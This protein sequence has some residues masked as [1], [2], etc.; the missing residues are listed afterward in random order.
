MDHQS[1]EEFRMIKAF[2]VI[3]LLIVEFFVG[4]TSVFAADINQPKPKLDL[5][6]LKLKSFLQLKSL[7]VDKSQVVAG[8]SASVVTATVSLSFVAPPSGAAVRFSV[9]PNLQ[10]AGALAS[11]EV[12]S[13]TIPQGHTSASVQIRTFPNPAYASSTLCTLTASY[14]GSS[15][16]VTFTVERLRIASMVVLPATGF[17]GFTATGTLTLSAV[18]APGTTIALTSDHPDVVRFGTIGN[19]QNS[20]NLA[21]DGKSGAIKTFTVVVSSVPKPTTAAIRAT[22]Y[23]QEVVSQI[24][25]K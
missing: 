14:G 9:A 20:G 6:Q 24:S 2:L 21:F 11:P 23:K 16:T 25:V 4:V 15:K 13:V 7:N 5:D 1:R 3:S 10:G 12:A 17:G 22:L 19:A 8:S 18:P